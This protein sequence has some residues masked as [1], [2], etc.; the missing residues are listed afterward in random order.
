MNRQ[1]KG[2]KVI[3]SN[4]V[5]TVAGYII[6]LVCILFGAWQII[7]T[8]DKTPNSL[9]LGVI[10][11]GLGL[12]FLGVLLM[13]VEEIILKPEKII[14]VGNFSEE[15]LTHQQIYNISMYTSRGRYGQIAKTVTIT[16][17]SGGSI[18]LNSRLGNPDFIYNTLMNWWERPNENVYTNLRPD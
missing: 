6:G 3:K 2:E 11:I 13:A 5:K 14:I 10:F 17:A 8:W 9:L 1:S 4:I 18:T 7:S 12:Y 16:R 15:E